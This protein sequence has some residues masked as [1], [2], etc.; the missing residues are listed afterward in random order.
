MLPVVLDEAFAQI[1]VFYWHGK[2]CKGLRTRNRLYKMVEAF[3]FQCRDHAFTLVNDLDRQ[4]LETYITVSPQGYRVWVELKSL[5]R[6]AKQKTSLK[7][8]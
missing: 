4:G 8:Y 2:F 6:C 1:F 7:H 3:D 5:N